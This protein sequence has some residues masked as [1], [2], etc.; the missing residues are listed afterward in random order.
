MALP[1]MARPAD[2]S[3]DSARSSSVSEDEDLP[4]AIPER[5]WSPSVP[6]ALTTQATR[7]HNIRVRREEQL[8]DVNSARE[9]QPSLRREV[10]PPLGPPT[11]ALQ[12]SPFLAKTKPPSPPQSN[13]FAFGGFVSDVV[14]L[15][16]SSFSDEDSKVSC[17]FSYNR[18]N[19]D[20]IMRYRLMSSRRIFLLVRPRYDG[21]RVLTPS[22]HPHI[23]LKYRRH[24]QRM[25]T[26]LHQV[27]GKTSH[28]LVVPPPVRE[29]PSAMALWIIAPQ[30][31]LLTRRHLRSP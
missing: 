16:S 30:A 7:R 21:T 23:L 3:S 31:F 25:R 26:H 5:P 20:V 17:L 4:L 28:R 11:P 24:H 19:C 27:A 29:V 13:S 18:L 12:N 22:Y 15:P 2:E 8:E 1:V 6:A 9:T 14:G 10:P